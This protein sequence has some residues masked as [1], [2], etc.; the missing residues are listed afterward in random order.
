MHSRDYTYSRSLSLFLACT[1][2]QGG[3]GVALCTKKNMLMSSSE[4][5]IA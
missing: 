3:D 2:Y 4:R 5:R 1:K